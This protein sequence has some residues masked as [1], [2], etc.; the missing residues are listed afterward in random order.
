VA[1]VVVVVVVVV[2]GGCVETVVELLLIK[3]KS[4]H[5]KEF[6]DRKF[7]VLF[8]IIVIISISIIIV[9]EGTPL[10]FRNVNGNSDRLSQQTLF[11]QH[12]K[13][14]HWI[15]I[16]L[17]YFPRED[18]LRFF[19]GGH[20]T[21]PQSHHHAQRATTRKRGPCETSNWI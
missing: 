1:L 11:Q 15:A 18:G 6:L 7:I 4:F 8:Y 19:H 2:V 16:V 14:E 21:V 20:L 5:G 13:I 3:S 12:S 10:L 9:V 17:L